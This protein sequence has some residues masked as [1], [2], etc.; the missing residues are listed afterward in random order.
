MKYLWWATIA[1]GNGCI[2]DSPENVEFS[3]RLTRG[4]TYAANFPKDALVRMSSD[5]KKRTVLLDDIANTDRIKICSPRLVEF[6]KERKIKNV[7]YLPIKIL[8]HKKKITATDYCI[9]HPIQLQDALD[10]KASKPT[11]SAI[12][13]TEIFFVNNLI[14]NQSKVDSMIKIFR[15]K[16]FHDPVLIEKKL[17]EEILAAGFKGCFFIRWSCGTSKIASFHQLNYS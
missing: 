6:L 16:N 5:A 4:V 2:V 17:A 3:P 11:W 1:V 10:I 15:L 9:V 8:N 12:E 13:K 7:E 14:I